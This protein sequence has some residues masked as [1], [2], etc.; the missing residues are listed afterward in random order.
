MPRGVKILLSVEVEGQPKTVKWFKGREELSSSQTTRIEKV[1]DEVY[2]LEIEKAELTDTGDYKVVLSTD[3][4]SIESS[5]NVT[6]TEPVEKPT[7]RKGLGDQ[8]LPKV[9]ECC[10]LS[11]FVL[12]LIFDLYG[13]FKWVLTI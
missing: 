10:L 8:S 12:L 3:T 6:V 13:K 11:N 9:G 5:C 2:R 4:E 7:F 1:T